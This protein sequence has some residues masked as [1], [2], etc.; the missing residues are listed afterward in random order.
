MHA[1]LLSHDVVPLVTWT[2]HGRQ[3]GNTGSCATNNIQQPLWRDV[4]IKGTPE[5][6]LRCSYMGGNMSP[7]VDRDIKDTLTL[8]NTCPGSSVSIATR[9]RSGRLRNRTSIPRREKVLSPHSLLKKIRRL[10]RSSCC[11]CVLH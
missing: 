2:T 6:M 8:L 11:L 1:R 10:M 5:H 7:M 4:T 3:A 9:L